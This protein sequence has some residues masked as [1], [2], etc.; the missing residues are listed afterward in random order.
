MKIRKNQFYDKFKQLLIFSLS[1]WSENIVTL[2]WQQGHQP[3]LPLP[4]ASEGRMRK[5]SETWHLCDPLALVWSPGRGS[6]KWPVMASYGNFNLVLGYAWLR[7]WTFPKI[8]KPVYIIHPFLLLHIISYFISGPRTI[9]ERKNPGTK[10]L[11]GIKRNSKMPQCFNYWIWK[12]ARTKYCRFQ[13]QGRGMFESEAGAHIAFQHPLQRFQN[14]RVLLAQCW[15]EWVHY[16]RG[17][18]RKVV[19][20]ET[21][22]EQC[23]GRKRGWEGKEEE[24]DDDDDDDNE[25]E[26]ETGG[27]I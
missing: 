19:G 6:H 15:L 17:G 4:P 23:G 7:P 5:T 8:H 18:R 3:C 25:E 24:D 22:G 20:R 21:K 1:A 14:Q 10:L 27:D 2:G 12:S 26:A 9:Q 16:L 13:N 11:T